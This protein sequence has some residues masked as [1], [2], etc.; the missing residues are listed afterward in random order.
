MATKNRQ[1]WIPQ[2]IW[3]TPP[4]STIGATEIELPLGP[5]TDLNLGT[6]MFVHLHRRSNKLFSFL[7]RHRCDPELGRYCGM[8]L[9]GRLFP[10]SDQ[11]VSFLRTMIAPPPAYTEVDVVLCVFRALSITLLI[12][13]ISCVLEC[14]ARSFGASKTRRCE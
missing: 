8:P 11:G 10:L 3:R 7:F 14:V 4:G 9:S 1:V 6:A 13:G 12:N 5:P 2:P